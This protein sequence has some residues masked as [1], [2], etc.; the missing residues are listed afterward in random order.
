MKRLAA[1]LAEQGLERIDLGPIDR[2]AAGI[3]PATAPVPEGVGG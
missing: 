2:R 1:R 3:G